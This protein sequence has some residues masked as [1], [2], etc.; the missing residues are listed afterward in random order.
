M[1]FNF[2]F[3]QGNIYING[4]IGS[5]G[6]EIGVELID[7][8]TQVK[9]QPE[10]TSFKVHI[11]SEGGAVDV[12]FDIYNYLKSLGKPVEMVGSGRV[13]SIAT[14]IFMAGQTRILKEGTQFMIHLPWGGV[15][16]TAEE[17]E[18][19][20]KEVKAVEDKLIKFYSEVTATNKEAI[21]PL[22]RNETYLTDEQTLDLGFT[23]AKYMPV[24]AR[25]YFNSNT[26][27]SMTNLKEE[28]KNWL[29]TKFESIAN[30]FSSKKEI[31][32]VMLQDANGVTLDFADVAEDAMPQV[33]DVATVE[34]EPA[35]GE[36]LMPNGETYVFAAGELTEIIVP[37]EEEE[38]DVEALKAENESLK[39][40]LEA[41]NAEKETLTNQL[42][43]K[44]DT[45]EE[46]EKEVLALKKSITSKFDIDV[47][48]EKKEIKE[49]SKDSEAMKALAK[50][51]E[52]RK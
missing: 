2:A 37:A 39:E 49:N 52:K 51:K 38:E 17:I 31:K 50:L 18:N 19:F 30:L 22:L 24:A 42:T 48:A 15:D 43:E 21:Y 45:L 33:G 9:K 29:E 25:A 40:Q 34:G 23:T 46:V 26:D 35:E 14:V 10:A 8:I 1:F 41:M 27:K 36:Y 13:M 3:M 12:G 44:S 32:N 16:G 28:D 4:L 6:S 47:K 7:V 20:A 11:N 5:F